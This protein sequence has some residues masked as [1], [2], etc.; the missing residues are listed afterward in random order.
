MKRG[1]LRSRRRSLG[2]TS[3]FLTLGV[4]LGWAE[5]LY[6]REDVALGQVAT[7]AHDEALYLVLRT[8]GLPLDSDARVLTKRVNADQ[9]AALEVMLNRRVFDRVPAA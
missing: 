8:L 1:A 3:A 7:I 2:D 9:R 5:K 6:A 4:W